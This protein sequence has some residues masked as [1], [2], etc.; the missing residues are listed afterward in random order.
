MTGHGVSAVG[1][2]MA[3]LVLTGEQLHLLTRSPPRVMLT[4]GPG[5]G[6]SVTLALMAISWLRQGR[7][8]FVVSDKDGS[9][10]AS[11]VLR[12]TIHE[13]VHADPN[14]SPSAG[15]VFLHQ[16]DFWT[17]EDH[18][19]KAICALTKDVESQGLYVIFDEFWGHD[20]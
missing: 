10:A 18:V 17:K 4:G 15:Q 19:D 6:K 16:Y 14:K 13:T 5:V 2:R 3:M 12:H 7:H 9:L 20:K 1:E 11:H 8:V